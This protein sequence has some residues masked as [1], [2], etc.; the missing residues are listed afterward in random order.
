MTKRFPEI[1]KPGILRVVTL[2]DGPDIG[3]GIDL[4]SGKT[5]RLRI[6]FRDAIKIGQTTLSYSSGYSGIPNSDVSR[7]FPVDL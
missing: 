7:S 5:I 2:C 4:N 1:Y 6:P 3:I